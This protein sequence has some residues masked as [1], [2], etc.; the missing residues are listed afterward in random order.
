M[1]FNFA[2]GLSFKA[3]KSHC[4]F[5]L[6]E[7]ENNKRILKKALESFKKPLYISYTSLNENKKEFCWDMVRKIDIKGLL[8]RYRAYRLQSHSLKLLGK[9]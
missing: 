3:F 1:N 7:K 6:K 8:R 5:I 2:I 9:Q 4:N